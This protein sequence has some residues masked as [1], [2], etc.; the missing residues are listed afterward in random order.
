MKMAELEEQGKFLVWLASKIANNATRGLQNV[1][2]SFTNQLAGFSVAI[3][4]WGLSQV[5]GS[6]YGEHTKLRD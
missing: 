1:G 4:E 2:K 3:T 5:V 6:F